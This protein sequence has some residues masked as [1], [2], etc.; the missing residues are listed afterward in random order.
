MKLYKNLKVFILGIVLIGLFSS[1]TIR[2][3][4]PIEGKWVLTKGLV[5]EYHV[6]DTIIF[7]SNRT[8]SSTIVKGTVNEGKWQRLFFRRNV[9]KLKSCLHGPDN[10]YKCR[11]F[12]WEWE[13]KDI[14]QNGMIV[15]EQKTF[16]NTRELIY[17]KIK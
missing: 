2:H 12:K 7:K 5:D 3:D 17:K 9:I 16:S 4:F 14:R 15:I 1:L 11:K 13:I 10:I 8:F 6:H